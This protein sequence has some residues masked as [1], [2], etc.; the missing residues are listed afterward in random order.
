MCKV[1]AKSDMP[2]KMLTMLLP[3]YPASSNAMSLHRETASSTISSTD[4]WASA[5]I[6]KDE[7]VEIGNKSADLI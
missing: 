1:V 5:E 6:F 7:A 4:W 2:F 3:G